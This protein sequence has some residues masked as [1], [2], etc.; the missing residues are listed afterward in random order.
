MK[1]LK[2]YESSFTLIPDNKEIT[3][4]CND[5]L[6]ELRDEGF[7]TKVK[8]YPS[9]VSVT[10]RRNSQF[11]VEDVLE[12]T[13]RISKCLEEFGYYFYPERVWNKDADRGFCIKTP[14]TYGDIVYVCDIVFMKKKTIEDLEA[15]FRSRGYTP[16]NN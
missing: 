2:T 1:H 15:W 12:T 8:Y 3:D 10:V 6:H 16:P 5:I 11:T 14:F 4:M 13:Y 7:T 9:Y